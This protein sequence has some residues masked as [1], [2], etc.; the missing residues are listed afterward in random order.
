MSWARDVFDFDPRRQPVPLRWHGW[1]SDT[2]SL[3][4]AGWQLSA[5]QDTYRDHIRIA[6]SHPRLQC[7]GITSGSAFDFYGAMRSREYVQ[8]MPPLSIEIGHKAF[9]RDVADQVAAHY[10]PE[11]D[12]LRPPVWKAIHGDPMHGRDLFMDV[13]LADF[14][15]FRPLSADNLVV[16]EESVAELLERIVK[17]QS[18]ARLERFREEVR[19]ERQAR[20]LI[21]PHAQIISFREAA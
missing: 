13:P 4:A 15:Y 9:I 2:L 7:E 14:C 11:P 10:R 3:Q 16:P 6:V 20:K 1:R 21:V 5:M 18:G 8:R 19:D 17:L 12:Y